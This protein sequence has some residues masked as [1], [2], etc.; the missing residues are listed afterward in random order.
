[1]NKWMENMIRE[2]EELN[3][4]TPDGVIVDADTI[5]VDLID[6]CDYE[7]SG[8]AQSIFNIWKCSTD[9]KAVEMMFY[10]FTDMEFED[11]LVKCKEEITR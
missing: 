1:M 5:L 11:Y 6:K 7:F 2:V 8:F 3:D 9:K 4:N 10:A